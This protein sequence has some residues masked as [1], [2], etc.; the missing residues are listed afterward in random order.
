M[1]LKDVTPIIKAILKER[2]NIPLTI[3]TERYLPNPRPNQYGS[4]MR[5]GLRK[6]LRIIE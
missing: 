6:A 1:Q 5:G 3:D 2:D 4:A